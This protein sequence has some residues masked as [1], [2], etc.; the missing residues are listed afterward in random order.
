MLTLLVL[1]FILPINTYGS[2]GVTKDGHICGHVCKKAGS[3]PCGNTCIKAGDVC[4][5]I[6]PKKDD[7]TWTSCRVE[8]LDEKTP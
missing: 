1:I 5:K 7:G 8:E 2:G 3:E 6:R 4:T